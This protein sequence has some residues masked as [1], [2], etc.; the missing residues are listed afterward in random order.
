MMVA[1]SSSRPSAGTTQLVPNHC[2][3]PDTV[4][5]TGRNRRAVVAIC[6]WTS[7]TEERAPRKSIVQCRS[8]ASVTSIRRGSPL[9]AD[10]SRRGAVSSAARLNSWS[11]TGGGTI[12]PRKYRSRGFSGVGIRVMQ[13]QT[14]V[15]AFGDQIVSAF[16][17]LL[18]LGH[19]PGWQLHLFFGGDAC[20]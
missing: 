9:C 4:T 2:N 1:A 15:A 18:D 12:T 20:L 16:S 11:R 17:Q 3:V 19:V 8:C 14:E 10:S 5:V 7:S 13:G 6:I